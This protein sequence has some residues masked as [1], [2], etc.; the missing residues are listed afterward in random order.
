MIKNILAILGFILKP[1]GLTAAMLPVLIGL[2][3]LLTFSL[4]AQSYPT[5]A[6]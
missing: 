3:T 4:T 6:D 2:G 5:D 1:L